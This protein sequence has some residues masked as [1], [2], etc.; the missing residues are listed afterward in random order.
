MLA[1]DSVM[2][3][4]VHDGFP[5]L[6]FD[7]PAGARA[8]IVVGGHLSKDSVAQ[9]ERRIAEAL[10]V[11][12]VQQFLIYRGA[13]DDDFRAPRADA[14]DLAAFRDWQARQA[15]GKALHFRG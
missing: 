14:F 4:R 15:L 2:V 6:E 7:L 8:A 10:K 13:G 12:P 11:K 5:A 1:I 9:A 3:D